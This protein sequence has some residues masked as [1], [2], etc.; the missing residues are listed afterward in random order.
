VVF[1]EM[2]E[3]LDLIGGFVE[4]YFLSYGMPCTMVLASFP[5]GFG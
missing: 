5:L 3:Q 4:Y 2:L 1:V